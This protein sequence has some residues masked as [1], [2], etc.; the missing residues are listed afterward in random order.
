M[1]DRRPI[2]VLG[3]LILGMAFQGFCA[4]TD[5]EPPLWVP[6]TLVASMVVYLVVDRPHR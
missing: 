4:A 3:Y 1:I 6:L 5:F 2:V